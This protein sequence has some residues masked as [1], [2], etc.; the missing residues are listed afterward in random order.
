M[1]QDPTASEL[2][3]HAEKLNRKTTKLLLWAA[4]ITALNIIL[5]VWQLSK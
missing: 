5:I 1:K 3:E 2:I 4:G